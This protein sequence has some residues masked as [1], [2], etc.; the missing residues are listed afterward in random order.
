MKRQ[1]IYVYI[2]LAVIVLLPLV[3]LAALGALSQRRPAHL[4]VQADG[5]L[6]P[7]PAAPNCISSQAE[8][9]A[10][11]AD[12]LPLV[13]TPAET[14][15]RLKEVLAAMPRTTVVTAND[16]Y[17]HAECRSRL[18]GFVDDI[19]LLVDDRA[20]VI[21]IRSASRVGYSDLGVNRKRVE[22]IRDRLS[23]GKPGAAP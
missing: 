22:Q 20:K 19:E 21:Q 12:P 8:D 14:L 6:A 9:E 16:R 5:R 7:C 4:G 15:E 11:R 17:L 13:G 10:H 2:A 3:G 18:I 1:M 23:R